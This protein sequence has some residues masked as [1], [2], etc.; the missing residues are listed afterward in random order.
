MVNKIWQGK[1]IRRAIRFAAV[2]AFGLI[3]CCCAN[4][5]APEGGKKDTKPPKA[6]KMSPPNKSLHFASNKIE[7]TFNKYIKSTGFSQTLISPPLDKRPDFKISNKTL[8][9]KFKSKLRD[10]TTY[11]INF[12]DDI[13][14]VNEGNIL[15]NFTYV[16]STG[17]FIDSQ[18]LSGKVY[19]A[20]DN[21]AADG[22]IVSLYPP[23][24][25]NAIK[26]SKPF[27][28]A[29]TDKSGSF[30][31]NNIRS[32]YYWVF[33]LK[34]ENY[35][36]I[37]DQPN[38]LI[39]FSDTMVYLNDTLPQTNYAPVLKKDS[40]LLKKDTLSLK[41]DSLL[42][43]IDEHLTKVDLYL[44]E[45]GGKNRFMGSKAVAPGNVQ[46]YYSKPVKN[47]TVHVEPVSE[48]VLWY[49]NST[50]D[51]INYWFSNYYD[52]KATFYLSANDTIKDTTKITLK[53]ITIDSFSNNQKLRLSIV[54]QTDTSKLIKNSNENY[55]TEELYKPVKIFFT[56]PVVEINQSKAFHLFEDSVKKDFP[57][58]FSVD[59][60]SKLSVSLDFVKDE[61]QKYTLE[62]PDS[63]F[64]DIFG[65][66]NRKIIYKFKTTSKDAYGNINLTLKTT[67]PEKNYLVRLI[68]GSGTT[69]KEISFTGEKERK[70]SIP[71]V[72]AGDYK[73]SA[74]DDANNNGQWD[75]GD[76]KNR[77]QPEKV[78]TF[79]ET[80]TLKG[81]W[82]M[83][84]EINL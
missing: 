65:S 29:K 14:D 59:E 4:E 48:R 57:A 27:Y 35:N 19:L 45:D 74:V 37:F 23:D 73:I 31:I 7:I 80:H 50:K 32:G 40:L 81:A 13:K 11:T 83:E 1:K 34:D 70:I 17:D 46:F 71:N 69:I 26:K 68:D 21:T 44:F 18:R 64:K 41:K 54:N 51:T 58:L 20:K 60:P 49:P 3:L 15:N 9:I 77:K 82:D 56:R 61:N 38:E 53:Y 75:T 62:F 8:I 72:A 10:S 33:A 16:F 30:Q 39:A 79:K 84:I 24:S 76:F 63:S 12:A 2:I 28:F 5:K 25:V 47:F 36:Y 52:K 42:K 67:H 43:K 78:I 22:V 66:W 55:V 6:K